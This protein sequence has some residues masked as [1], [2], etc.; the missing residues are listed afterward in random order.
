MT[1]YE[2]RKLLNDV[3]EFLRGE[4]EAYQDIKKI[5]LKL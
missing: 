3:F 2:V 4:K 1:R 5:L